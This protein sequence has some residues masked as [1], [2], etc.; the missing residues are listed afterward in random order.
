[1]GTDFILQG[2]G[3]DTILLLIPVTKEA[4]TWADENLP[5]EKQTF[6]NGIV[7]ENRF[8]SDIIDGIQRDGLTI[9][10]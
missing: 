6:G 8:V 1:M 7:I 4:K 9:G 2:R 5:E 10:G 3:T